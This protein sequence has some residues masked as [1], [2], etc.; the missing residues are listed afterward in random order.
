MQV[1]QFKSVYHVK[2]LIVKYVFIKKN[3]SPDQR[4]LCFWA[5]SPLLCPSPPPAPPAISG[6]RRRPSAPPRTCSRPPSCP[7]GPRRGRSCERARTKCRQSSGSP[8]ESGFLKKIFFW[9]GVRLSCVCGVSVVSIAPD[10]RFVF[11]LPQTTTAC[12]KLLLVLSGFFCRFKNNDISLWIVSTT[13]AWQETD[14]PNSTSSSLLLLVP[15]GVT[16]SGRLSH[17]TAFFEREKL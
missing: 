11:F 15:P 4:L 12:E 10:C 1:S 2:I 14:A 8:L 13:S 6:M 7:P 9:G 16:A 3:P 5:A 17:S